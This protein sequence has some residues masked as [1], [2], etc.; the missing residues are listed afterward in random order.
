MCKKITNIIING[1]A[2]EAR[3]LKKIMSAIGNDKILI[4]KGGY[5]FMVLI[6][7]NCCNLGIQPYQINGERKFHYEL[8][9]PEDNRLMTGFINTNHSVTL[10]IKA[11]AELCDNGLSQDQKEYFYEAY[12]KFARFLMAYGF[13]SHF[14]IDMLTGS[15]LKE[16]GIMNNVPLNIK[17]LGAL[18]IIYPQK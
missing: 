17:E 3:Q 4:E 13:P 10:L 16:T 14:E 7:E 8:N 9:M 18:P 12:V 6:N 15:L 2:T 5:I 11:T 1:K